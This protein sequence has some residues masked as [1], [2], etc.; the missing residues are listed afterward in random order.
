MN[1]WK[2]FIEKRNSNKMLKEMVQKT[3]EGVDE[4]LSK[5][6]SNNSKSPIENNLVDEKHISLMGWTVACWMLTIEIEIKKGLRLKNV[7]RFCRLFL[8]QEKKRNYIKD[9]NSADV[10]LLKLC[11]LA[12]DIKNVEK[13]IKEKWTYQKAKDFEKEIGYN[14]I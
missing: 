3:H 11:S 8:E 7:V 9:Y 6:K 1:L 5:V 14:D 12:C 10:Q 4:E 2:K 13:L